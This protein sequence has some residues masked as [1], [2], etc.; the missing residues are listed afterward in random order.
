MERGG[1]EE[2]GKGKREKE[3]ERAKRAEKVERATRAKKVERAV[4]VEKKSDRREG[5]QTGK[6]ESN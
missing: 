4:R 2:R 6:M 5:R 1:S 3:V